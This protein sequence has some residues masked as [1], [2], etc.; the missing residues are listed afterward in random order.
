MKFLTQTHVDRKLNYLIGIA[1]L[2]KNVPKAIL[3]DELPPVS[4]IFPVKK[5]V[6]FLNFLC[7]Q[8]VPLLIDSL[9]FADTVLKL[10]TLDLFAFSLSEATHVMEKNI[11]DLLPA[12]IALIGPSEKSMQVR[13]AALKCIDLVSVKVSRD[14][15]LPYTK[16][17]LKAISVPL[18]DKKRLVR[19]Q[20]VECRE[21]WY[22]IGQKK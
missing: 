17:T 11:K 9:S 14:I 8:L 3:I 1:Y 7:L 16:E 10:S 13:I 2:L 15:V 21:S 19:K 18:D 12:F 20:A 22:L 4:N 5:Q 6:F